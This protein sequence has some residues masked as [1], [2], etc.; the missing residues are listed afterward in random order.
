MIFGF[1]IYNLLV[2]GDLI[3]MVFNGYYV[4]LRW[5]EMVRVLCVMVMFFNY[6]INDSLI[7]FEDEYVVNLKVVIKS[8]RGNGYDV[9]F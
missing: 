5:L 9:I 7:I 2:S 4:N 3:K 1:V 8:V 6:G